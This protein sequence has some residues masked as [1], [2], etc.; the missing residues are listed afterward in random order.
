MSAD[1][2]SVAGGAAAA[3]V[4]L[5]DG[6]I[7]SIR[8]VAAQD[9][10]ALLEL[11]ARTSDASLQRRFLHVSRSAADAYVRHVCSAPRGEVLALVA[12]VDGVVVALITCE[13]VEPGTAE[14]SVIVD[15]AHQGRGLGTLLLAHLAAWA[16]RA[17]ITLFTALVAAT[18]GAMINVFRDAGF[19]VEM[20]SDGGTVRVSMPTAVTPLVVAAN[21]ARG[22]T[23]N[24]RSLLA[25]LTPRVV[26]VAGAGRTPGGVGRA[27]LENILAAGFT[28]DLFVIHP[29]AP[30]IAGVRAYP[31]IRD[32]PM[33]V[34]LLIVAVPADR[35][36]GLVEDAAE[37]GVKGAVV[38]TAGLGEVGAA[39]VERQR[40]MVRAARRH[41]MRLIGPNCLGIINSD[42]GVRLDATFGSTTATPGRLAIGSQSG[43]VGI[44]AL[45]RASAAGLGVA[46]FVSLGNKADVSGNDLLEAWTEDPRIG[47]VGLYLESFGNPRKFARLARFLSER[48]PLLA[49]VGGRSEG[50]RRAGASHTAAAAAPHVAVEALF[51]QSGVIGVDSIEEL[52]DA[53]RV[54]IDRPLPG[55]PRLAIIGNAGGLGV[56]AA[57]SANSLGLSVPEFSADGTAALAEAIPGA[58]GLQNPVDLGAAANAEAFA[59]GLRSVTAGGE[60][61]AVLAMFT[62]TR[63][64]D[65]PAV[66]AAIEAAAADAPVPVIA[67]LVGVP[68]EAASALTVPVF[69]SAAAAIRA[70]GHAVRYATW[71]ATP[72]EEPA[73]LPGIDS[74]NARELL[75]ASL[76]DD[77]RAEA[78]P[79]S[80]WLRPDESTRLLSS[81]ELPTPAFAVVRSAA[82]ASAAARKIGFPVVLKVADPDVVHKTDLGLVATS[83]RSGTDVARAYR[84][85]ASSLEMTRPLVLVQRQVEAGVE[86]AIGAV[87]DPAFG[88]LV[89]VAA[90]GIHIDVLDDRAF[91]LP[92][93]TP[94]DARRAVE[95]LRIAPLLRGF[96]GSPPADVEG[97]VD[98]IVRVAAMVAD[99]PEIAEMDLNPVI[100]TA[101]GVSCVDAKVR[102]RPAPPADDPSR[103]ALRPA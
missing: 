13:R 79:A 59:R 97:L 69:G 28:G 22:R 77:G 95:S 50:G 37:A 63:V 73:D 39:G 94:Q 92:P 48:K 80:R 6:G 71:R 4:L 61:D 34:D 78:A 51:A 98:V 35:V 27:V 85:F 12:E 88:P 81:Y 21:D 33:P 14:V 31:S 68:A 23:A 66:V 8:P 84:R 1:V 99:L 46:Q 9:L 58:A 30:E 47:A 90:G 45:V 24:R 2:T 64:G 91:L 74:V 87:H 44:A 3:D 15:D 56:L 52:V 57:D 75:A 103:P 41:G 7:A 70:I 42:P 72:H 10:P 60:V 20:A 67:V 43:G 5:A 93:V 83:L 89:M 18:N 26:A 19:T 25:L 102:V 100:V 32:V 17:G 16:R 11:N 40:A 53:A 62:A 82:A 65:A 38:L 49:V 55:G 36:V 76:G 29:A 96:R 101:A 86:L 54:L